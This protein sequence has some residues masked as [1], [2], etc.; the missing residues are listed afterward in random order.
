LDSKNKIIVI[1]AVLIIAFTVFS[2]LKNLN[3]KEKNI[4]NNPEIIKSCD[5]SCKTENCL[6]DCYESKVNIAAASKDIKLCNDIKPDS[7]KSLCLDKV[8]F[9]LNNCDKILNQ[10]LK[11]ICK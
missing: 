2:Y 1:L 4:E 6:Y 5:E 7:V 10:E 8:H 11:A 3:F 9:A